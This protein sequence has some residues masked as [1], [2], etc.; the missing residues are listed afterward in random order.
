[1]NILP[2]LIAK[3][4][5]YFHMLICAGHQQHQLLLQCQSRRQPATVGLEQCALGEVLSLARSHSWT[6]AAGHDWRLADRWCCL[7]Y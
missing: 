2:T 7:L 4:L 1:M 6:R 5:F 3:A